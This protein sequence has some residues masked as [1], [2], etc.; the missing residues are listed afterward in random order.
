MVWFWIAKKGQNG[1]SKGK[2]RITR[3]KT[4]TTVYCLIISALNTK[5]KQL[6][7]ER[8][9]LI[10]ALKLQQHEFEQGQSQINDRE[11]WHTR[12]TKC[13]QSVAHE[14]EKVS[15][16]LTTQNSFCC[17][18]RWDERRCSWASRATAFKKCCKPYS[19]QDTDYFW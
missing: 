6:E 8:D 5:M 17:L 10:T 16:N 3:E 4:L 2:F 12:K 14:N 18:E 9:S 11:M 19:C 13:P 1:I 15:S 7:H